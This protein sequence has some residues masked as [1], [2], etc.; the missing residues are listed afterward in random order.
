MIVPHTQSILKSQVRRLVDNGQNEEALA[1][2]KRFLEMERDAALD[3]AAC[4]GNESDLKVVH[5][6]LLRP[7]S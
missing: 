4:S 5:L 7:L 6:P 1:A 2:L 3:R